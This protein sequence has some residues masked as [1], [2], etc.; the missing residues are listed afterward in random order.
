MIVTISL[1]VSINHTK[2][3]ETNN[4]QTN[5]VYAIVHIVRQMNCLSSQLAVYQFCLNCEAMR[6][7]DVIKSWYPNEVLSDDEALAIYEQL[8]KLF[9]TLYYADK[10]IKE[11]QNVS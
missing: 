9:L 3:L 6:K 10:E 8:L 11:I 7:E 4:F 1:D 2:P 5:D